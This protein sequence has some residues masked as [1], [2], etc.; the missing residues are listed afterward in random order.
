MWTVI[1]IF[2][3]ILLIH[4]NGKTRCLEQTYHVKLF[5]K[6]SFR[7]IIMKSYFLISFL[8]CFLVRYSSSTLVDS[9]VT[10]SWSLSGTTPVVDRF[11]SSNTEIKLKLHCTESTINKNETKDQRKTISTK[12]NDKTRV[13]IKGRIGRV[14]ACLPLQ[15]D[16]F[17]TT[18]QL[19]SKDT[20][21]SRNTLETLYI[22]LWKQMEIRE[23][24]MQEVN[25]DYP[26]ELYYQEYKNI[27][28]PEISP[29]KA[30]EKRKQLLKQEREQMA[31]N[32]SKII[33][34]S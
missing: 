17:M 14:V 34:Q 28:G 26:G 22:N 29:E 7:L 2:Y 27:T 10:V 25:C 21:D 9:I 20:K 24:T 6:L 15:P 1:L 18:N 13:Q 19:S 8:F 30:A 4:P 23:F 33:Y 5:V 32:Q 31:A 11:L 16:S 3:S 12:E